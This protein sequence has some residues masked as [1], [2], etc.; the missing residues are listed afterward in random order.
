MESCTS[1]RN[2]HLSLDLMCV[3]GVMVGDIRSRKDSNGGLGWWKR[4]WLVVATVLAVGAVV[5]AA[6]IWLI[7]IPI[8]L[9]LP[10]Q[11]KSYD[12]YTFLT[13]VWVQVGVAAVSTV[14]VGVLA[15]NNSI[16]QARAAAK[17]KRDSDLRS[18]SSQLM[19]HQSSAIEHLGAEADVVRESGLKELIWLMRG[20]TTLTVDSLAAIHEDNAVCI[21]GGN[22]E[23]ASDAVDR[24]K[25]HVQQLVDLV[26]KQNWR[27]DTR[28]FFG[29]NDSLAQGLRMLSEQLVKADSQNLAANQASSPVMFSAIDL[30]HADLAGMNLEGVNLEGVNLRGANLKN[31]NLRGAKLEDAIFDDCTQF[32]AGAD[33]SKMIH[34]DMC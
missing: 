7:P 8:E 24:W 33:T 26:Y 3:K 34:L 1:A 4:W 18:R 10:S 9:W 21:K 5:P 32:P 16:E 29:K 2:T 25:E 12:P 27:K 6:V 13:K 15:R 14:F 30:S 31:A 20:W 17:T 23:Q 28:L 19:S 22:D 11:F